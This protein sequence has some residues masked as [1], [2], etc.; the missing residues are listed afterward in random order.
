MVDEFYEDINHGSQHH[1]D[2]SSTGQ[3]RSITRENSDSNET[4]PIRSKT[5]SSN[6]TERRSQSSEEDLQEEESDDEHDLYQSFRESDQS[7]NQASDQSINQSTNGTPKQ[8]M[9]HRGEEDLT[10]TLQDDDETITEDQLSSAASEEEAQGITEDQLT[11]AAS[12]EEPQ[13]IEPEK[14]KEARPEPR[15]T[16]NTAPSTET[17]SSGSGTRR[18]GRITKPVEKYDPYP[19][20]RTPRSRTRP[21]VPKSLRRSGSSIVKTIKSALNE[22]WENTPQRMGPPSSRRRSR[23]RETKAALLE[24]LNQTGSIKINKSLCV[25]RKTRY[26]VENR[27]ASRQESRDEGESSSWTDS[28]DDI[29]KRK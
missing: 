26:S 25:D 7:I 8:Q 2:D 23:S 15:I 28:E 1:D 20:P 12:E 18:S 21:E 24:K 10:R 13:E 16:E 22:A 29:D 27:S 19:R 3:I 9:E 11:S 4:E 5:R 14:Q 6:S 17:G